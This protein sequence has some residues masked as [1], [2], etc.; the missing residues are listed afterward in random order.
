MASHLELLYALRAELLGRWLK[1]REK[2][3][4][5]LK[6][7]LGVEEEIYQILKGSRVVG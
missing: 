5:L 7:I 1:E 4:Q 2:R 3:G 6:E